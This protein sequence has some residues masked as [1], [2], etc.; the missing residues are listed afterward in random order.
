MTKILF[1]T[2]KLYQIVALIGI[3]FIFSTH[4]VAATSETRVPTLEYKIKATYLVNFKKYVNW[5][6]QTRTS[7]SYGSFIIGIS[8]DDHAEENVPIHLL[9]L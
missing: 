9:I 3:I 4:I 1:I 8:A 6:G 5:P 7:V 2:S